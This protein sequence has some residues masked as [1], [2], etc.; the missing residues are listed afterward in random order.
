M[1]ESKILIGL[2][3]IEYQFTQKGAFIACSKTDCQSNRRRI[4]DNKEVL[5]TDDCP[6]SITCDGYSPRL[7]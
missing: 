4:C 5:L 1:T 3:E 7:K 6:L 2:P